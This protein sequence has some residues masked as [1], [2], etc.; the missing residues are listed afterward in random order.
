MPQPIRRPPVLI[1]GGGEKKTLRLVA[2]YADL[3]NS[4]STDPAELAHKIDVLRRHCDDVGRNFSEI[5]LTAA[6]P[7][8]PFN[9]AFLRTAATFAELGVGL[10]NVVPHPGNPDPVGFVRRLGDDVI[11]RLAELG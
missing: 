8:D 10:V 7:T 1:G 4:T 9:D 2:Q 11:P 3:W 5:R 6:L